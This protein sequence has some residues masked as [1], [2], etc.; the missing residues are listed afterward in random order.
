MHTY[1]CMYAYDLYNLYVQGYAVP[2]VFTDQR[3]LEIYM[4]SIL[5]R[6]NWIQKKIQKNVYE[7]LSV[8]VGLKEMISIFRFRLLQK[9]DYQDSYSYMNEI[10]IPGD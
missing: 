7:Y 3:A 4:H 10:G 6:I 8:T 1:V 2:I 5:Y 9:I